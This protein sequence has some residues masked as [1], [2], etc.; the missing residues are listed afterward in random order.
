MYQLVSKAL[1]HQILTWIYKKKEI[2]VQRVWF[3]QENQSLKGEC[4]IS[5]GAYTRIPIKYVTAENFVRCCSQLGYLIM[6][7]VKESD[8]E[9]LLH[10]SRDKFRELMVGHSMFY[11]FLAIKFSQQIPKDV[12]FTLTLRLEKILHKSEMTVC[13]LAIGGAIQGQLKFVGVSNCPELGLAHHDNLIFWLFASWGIPAAAL[14]IF[15]IA[16]DNIQGLEKI[17][18]A[19]Y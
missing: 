4:Q 16:T 11:H 1:W 3:S 5:K 12:P 15:A 17:L 9:E 10:V 8:I 14:V 13:Y 2:A 7:L 18:M 19:F 6:Y